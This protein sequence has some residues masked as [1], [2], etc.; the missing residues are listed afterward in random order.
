VA[1][2]RGQGL[3]L[4]RQERLEIP[5]RIAAGESFEQTAEA[6]RCTTSRMQ[7][8]LNG[9]GDVH[10]R[11]RDRSKLRL[12]R[13]EWEEISLGLEAGESVREIADRLDRAPSA[14]A[15]DVRNNGGRARYRAV[16]A[17]ESGYSAWGGRGVSNHG[18]SDIAL[19]ARIA[20]NRRASDT[21]YGTPRIHVELNAMGIRV[22]RRR[23]GRL[24][25]E[26]GLEG[27]SRRAL[28]SRT[29]DPEHDA[30]P[31]PSSLIA[32]TMISDYGVSFGQAHRVASQGLGDSMGQTLHSGT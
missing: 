15:R 10:P 5:R 3:R 1:V 11:E 28:P 23:V 16:H 13:A 26:L 25:G 4:T 29:K 9:V 21:R 7:R 2:N 27:V 19:A 12:S 8:L 31:G 6:V 32:T 30:R 14:I 17:D 18:A 24:M 22:G 20:A